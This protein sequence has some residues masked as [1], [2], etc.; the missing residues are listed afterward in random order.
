VVVEKL[1]FTK[2]PKTK[3]R[4]DALPKRDWSPQRPTSFCIWQDILCSARGLMSCVQDEA[5]CKLLSHCVFPEGYEASAR[6][7][8][9]KANVPHFGV[10]LYLAGIGRH[11]NGAHYACV[12]VRNGQNESFA[13][14]S[15][16]VRSTTTPLGFLENS[17][18]VNGCNDF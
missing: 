7:D 9:K 14:W 8:D 6:K 13:R 12:P 16:R 2:S 3:L 17:F 11:R 15:S 10:I 4:Q 18:L 1:F 5:H